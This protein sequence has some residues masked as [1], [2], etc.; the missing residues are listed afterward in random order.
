MGIVIMTSDKYRDVWTP[1]YHLMEKYW[2]DCTYPI[3]HI[4]EREVPAT[5]FPI[6]HIES[7]PGNSWNQTLSS[8]LKRIPENFILLLLADFFLLR[9]VD[10]SRIEKYIRILEEENVAFIRIFPCP[11][12]HY[13]YKNYVDIGLIEK[14]TPYSI[15]T[16]ATIWNKNDLEFFIGKFRDDSELEILGSQR[17]DELEKDLLS[18]TVIDKTSKLED[19]NY[20]FTY[21]CTAVIQGKWNRSA[22]ELCARENID[23]DLSYRKRLS[24]LE[25]YYYY[26]YGKIPFIL[27]HL[28]SMV[29]PR[30]Q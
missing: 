17:S 3:Y 1:F 18:V 13:D 16:Q 8:A 4:S 28:I 7:R 20:A 11:G 24:I 27:R 5:S 25:T 2:A 10:T 9:P 22:A 12:P 14:K 23:L 30:S 19:Q 21:L 15:S 29:L 6:H 26:N